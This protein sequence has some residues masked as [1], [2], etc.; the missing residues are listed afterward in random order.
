[1]TWR[2]AQPTLSPQAGGER[3]RPSPHG[4]RSRLATS[5][6]ARDSSC[7][8]LCWDSF[9]ANPLREYRV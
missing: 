5:S 9:Y 2:K 7:A 1:M 6:K 3:E 4:R 8:N